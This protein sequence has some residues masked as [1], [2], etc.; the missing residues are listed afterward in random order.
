MG[1]I[2]AGQRFGKLVTRQ[3]IP[4]TKKSPR[5][6]P[7]WL[8]DCDCGEV[9]HF[10]ATDN[11]ARDLSKSCGCNRRQGRTIDESRFSLSDTADE[12]YWLGMMAT[13]GNVSSP[14]VFSVKL[15][16]S[17]VDA[18]HVSAFARFLGSNANPKITARPN[19]GFGG[20]PTATFAVGSKQI[21]KSLAAQGIHPRKTWTV[22]PWDGPEHLL[23]HYWRGCVDGDGSVIVGRGPRREFCV[24]FCGNE[25]M[26]RGMSEFVRRH[27]GNPGYIGARITAAQAKLP[28]PKVFAHVRWG[29]LDQCKAVLRLLRYDDLDAVALER[30]R[31]NAHTILSTETGHPCEAIG[32][33]ELL[34]SF[35]ECRS[36]SG[37]ARRF[38]V[39]VDG[40]IGR[41]ARL[42]IRE[43]DVESM[44]SPVG[45]SSNRER[46]YPPDVLRAAYE[47]LGT[48]G[49]VAASTGMS[50]VTVRQ[51][52]RRAPQ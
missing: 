39:S 46:Q 7:G 43:H 9:A 3:L 1:S 2:I 40:V 24:H 21:A 31:V 6:N 28:A 32:R 34:A 4:G 12:A 37:V 48:W 22:R 8:C 27:T 20:G 50:R 25:A 23:P 10:V 38:G 35:Q 52:M 13:D 30:K 18:N 44:R 36:W 17:A 14:P 33:D 15:S 42:G 51:I 47:R 16:L 19:S 11:L 5:R 26:V 41:V 49:A 45:R 29:G